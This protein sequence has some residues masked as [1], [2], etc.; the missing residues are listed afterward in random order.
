MAEKRDS[1]EARKSIRPSKKLI[2]SFSDGAAGVDFVEGAVVEDRLLIDNLEL[3]GGIETRF[4]SGTLLVDATVGVV[5]S[6]EESMHVSS[7]QW[8]WI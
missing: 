8:C 7:L 2:L 5:L 4:V 6:L 3:F 1:C